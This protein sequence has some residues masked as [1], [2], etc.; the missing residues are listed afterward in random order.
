M[1][2]PDAIAETCLHMI[3]RDHGVWAMV[4]LAVPRH[5]SFHDPERAEKLRADIAEGSNQIDFPLQE[6]T[7]MRPAS[8]VAYAATV[9]RRVAERDL[10][11]IDLALYPFAG[12]GTKVR[13]L[14]N[15]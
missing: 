10:L 7:D 5:V 6:L 1:L 2:D 13:G 8:L 11:A 15:G 4:L 9:E 3:R 12:D 14:R